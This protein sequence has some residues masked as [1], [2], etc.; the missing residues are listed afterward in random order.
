MATYSDVSV[1][2]E[3]SAERIA[4]VN[5]ILA[6]HP[7]ELGEQQRK[8]ICID[9]T[10]FIGILDGQN[11]TY[12][13]IRLTNEAEPVAV[14]EVTS[15]T[16]DPNTY[17]QILDLA[18][19]ET[20]KRVSG[21]IQLWRHR[22]FP[23]DLSHL[24][25]DTQYFLAH[26]ARPAANLPSIPQ[27]PDGV[28]IRAFTWDDLEAFVELNNAAFTSHEDQS[29]WSLEKARARLSQDWVRFDE[30]FLAEENGDLLAFHWTKRHTTDEGTPAGEVYIIGVHPK[31]QGRGLGKV[32][33]L[34]GLHALVN[35][36]AEVL[37]LW[38]NENEE[39]P[40]TLYQTMGFEPIHRSQS[41][42]GH[43][44]RLP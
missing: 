13:H 27:I 38:V 9:A 15:A 29:G 1:F 43:T 30:L 18:L 3:F 21:P 2:S 4:A 26:M 8:Q 34:T 16:Q 23:V 22:P 11:Q 28:V 7:W 33:L 20:A 6:V 39:V 40:Y 32:M 36:G 37:D 17:V 35:G 5:D 14:I 19:V 24:G 31:A 42:T 41:F 12:A 25:L 10:D 44:P